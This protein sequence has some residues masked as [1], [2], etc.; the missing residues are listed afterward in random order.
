MPYTTPFPPED[1]PMYDLIF[2][3]YGVDWL[4][5]ITT[6]LSLY[7]LGKKKRRGFIYGLAANASWLTFGVMAGSLANVLANTIFAALNVKG[8]RHWSR[9]GSPD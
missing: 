5:M 2:S 8:Y 9:E 3:Y 6:F 4:A 1:L 7:Y